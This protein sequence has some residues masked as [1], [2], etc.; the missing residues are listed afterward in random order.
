MKHYDYRHRNDRL[1]QTS[2][3]SQKATG[4]DVIK[5]CVPQIKLHDGPETNESVNKFGVN[6]KI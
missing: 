2:Q 6:N 4:S 5:A 3:L 1:L